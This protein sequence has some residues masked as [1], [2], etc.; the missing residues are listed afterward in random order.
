MLKMKV[1][2]SP[3]LL[4]ILQQC[5]FSILSLVMLVYSG[6][7][8]KPLQNQGDLILHGRTTVSIM[9]PITKAT[10][11]AANPVRSDIHLRL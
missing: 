8:L 3:H 2:K 11:S 7:K 4:L 10:A 9:K 5:G 1:N 6:E